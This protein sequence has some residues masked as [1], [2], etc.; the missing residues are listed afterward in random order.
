MPGLNKILWRGW[1]LLQVAFVLAVVGVIWKAL[2]EHLMARE[3]EKSAP[4][5]EALRWQVAWILCLLGLILGGLG[6]FVW[7]IARRARRPDP[8]LVFLEELGE[9]E[10]NQAGPVD[11]PEREPW[12]RPSDWWK[13]GAGGDDSQ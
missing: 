12:E 13:K 7:V 9:E 5:M 10:K 4:V 1:L 11:A 6:V 3:A 2:P 8:T